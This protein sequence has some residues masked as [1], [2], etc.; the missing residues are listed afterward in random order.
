[1]GF[2]ISAYDEQA[3]IDVS[4]HAERGYELSDS[5]QG[6]LSGASKGA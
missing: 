2:R 3:G 6:G 5:S 4:Y 1:M